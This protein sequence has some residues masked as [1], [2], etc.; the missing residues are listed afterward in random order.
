MLLPAPSRPVSRAL[1]L[2][3]FDFWLSMMS[4]LVKF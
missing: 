2:L 4:S 1:P 3:L